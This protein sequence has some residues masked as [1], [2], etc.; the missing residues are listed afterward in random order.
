MHPTVGV[1]QSPMS[2]PALSVPWCA[3]ASTS[4]GK[5][6]FIPARAALVEARPRPVP[7]LNGGVGGRSVGDDND[8][9]FLLRVRDSSSSASI[10]DRADVLQAEAAAMVRAVNA[11]VYSPELLAANYGSCPIKVVR[12]ALEIFAGL[13]SFAFSLWFDQVNRQLDRTQRQR[14]VHLRETFTRLGPTFVK[15]GQGLSTRPDLCP[16]QYLEE[17]SQ[18]QTRI[19]EII[20]F[21]TLISRLII[22]WGSVDLN[23]YLIWKTIFLSKEGRKIQ[24]NIKNLVTQIETDINDQKIIKKYTKIKE[25]RKIV[26][27]WSYKLKEEFDDI[28]SHLYIPKEPG[29]F[30]ILSSE[31]KSALMWSTNKLDSNNLKDKDPNEESQIEKHYILRYGIE[32]DFQRHYIMGSIR[33]QRRKVAFFKLF[34]T[35]G[36]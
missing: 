25:I 15:I 7:T 22:K 13:G 19:H 9:V 3:S 35:K 23:E 26:L 31:Y 2:T 14:A 12:R 34:Q 4:R 28:L 1:P 20:E 36:G 33:A 29:E 8:A 6:K 18:L 16:P 27:R 5:G 11:T 21:L 10:G 17:L 30:E 32:S 24:K